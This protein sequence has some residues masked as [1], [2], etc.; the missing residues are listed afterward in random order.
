MIKLVGKVQGTAACRNLM[1][2]PGALVI[3]LG[4]LLGPCWKRPVMLFQNTHRT[5]RSCM[6]CQCDT[7]SPCS[8]QSLATRKHPLHSLPQV[9]LSLYIYSCKCKLSRFSMLANAV[10]SLCRKVWRHRML[11]QVYMLHLL[12]AHTNHHKQWHCQTVLPTYIL[13][14]GPTLHAMAHR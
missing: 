4:R 6:R 2:N 5:A 10:I 9:P 14:T 7:V 12:T 3:W 8:L 1:S 13:R 11:S